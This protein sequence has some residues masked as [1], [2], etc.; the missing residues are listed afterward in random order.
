MPRANPPVFLR[1]VLVADA[2][3]SGATGALLWLAAA[4]IEP[5]TGLPAALLRPAGLLLLPF[6]AAVA[7]T[8][9]RDPLPRRAV[10]AVVAANAAWV[11]ASV[12]LLVSGLVEPTAVGYAFVVVQAVA[13]LALAELQ[14]IGLRR[15]GGTI[16]AA[17]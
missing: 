15:I 17:S 10:T 8:A 1:R 7:A 5:L 4:A 6:A 3:I 9:A 13:V 14:W 12:A 11:A 2:L 16:T